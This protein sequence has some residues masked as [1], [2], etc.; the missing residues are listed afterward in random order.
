[1]GNSSRTPEHRAAVSSTRNR[2]YLKAIQDGSFFGN[3]EL[4]A[5]VEPPGTPLQTHI[6]GLVSDEGVHSRLERRSPAL[7]SP[8]RGLR[9]LHP[10]F[11]RWARLAAHQRHRLHRARRAG[12]EPHRRRADRLRL[13][14][15][16]GHGSRQPPG[17]RTQSLSHADPGR[18]PGRLA[19]RGACNAITTTRSNQ[20]CGA[21]IRSPTVI[22]EDG[23][24]PL[25]TVG[26]GDAVIFFNFRGD[27]PRAIRLSRSTNSL[28]R[29]RQGGVEREM[30]SRPC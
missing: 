7:S 2:A 3:P 18:R 29:Q 28:S 5:A 19:A 20:T 12:T 25:A 24:L 27:R 11:H 4:V 1:M 9:S 6:M 26:S 16:L 13:R 21:T 23:R 10:R 15:L 30:G 22:S 17:P 14:P 8:R